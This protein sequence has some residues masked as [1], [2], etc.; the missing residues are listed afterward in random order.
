MF[1]KLLKNATNQ[2][3]YSEKQIRIIKSI[4]FPIWILGFLIVLY[5]GLNTIG[6]YS[7]YKQAENLIPSERERERTV[8]YQRRNEQMYGSATNQSIDFNSRQWAELGVEDMNISHYDTNLPEKAMAVQ[9]NKISLFI[10]ALLGYLIICFFLP[11]ILLKYIF[12]IKNADNT[13]TI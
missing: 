1:I 4:L 11:W 6:A 2:L 3:N 8:E 7:L 12:W 5:Y 13:K 10:T 9:M